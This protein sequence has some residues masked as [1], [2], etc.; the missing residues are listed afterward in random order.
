[1]EK[2][3]FFNKVIPHIKIINNTLG[4]FSTKNMP[5]MSLA[6]IKITGAWGLAPKS[7][8][9]FCHVLSRF[10][11]HVQDVFSFRE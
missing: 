7:P 9:P 11:K 6:V 4:D 8:P 5:I 1:M 2:S 10:F 3:Y